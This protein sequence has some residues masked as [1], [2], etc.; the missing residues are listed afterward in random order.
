[1]TSPFFNIHIGEK[2]PFQVNEAMEKLVIATRSCQ[3]HLKTNTA[4]RGHRHMSD[5]HCIGQWSCRCKVYVDSRLP[6]RHAR[7][8]IM[9]RVMPPATTIF[10]ARLEHDDTHQS[11]T[12]E[13]VAPIT[14][15]SVCQ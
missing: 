3:Q 6:C 13:R 12:S 15:P 10:V 11:E 14:A 5:S 1:M 4:I 7:C 9:T 2:S 8:S